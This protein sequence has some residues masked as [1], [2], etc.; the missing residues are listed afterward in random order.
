MMENSEKTG[1]RKNE[2]HNKKRKN[3]YLI[4]FRKET[5]PDSFFVTPNFMD[6]KN[7]VLRQRQ[8]YRFIL[9]FFSFY[10]SLV[11]EG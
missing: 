3:A 1:E 4:I 9:S 10:S 6:E 5:E 11:R 7:L 2:H 8:I